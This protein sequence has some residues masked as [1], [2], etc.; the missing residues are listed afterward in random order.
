LHYVQSFSPKVSDYLVS[1]LPDAVRNVALLDANKMLQGAAVR[2][3]SSSPWRQTVNQSAHQE[4]ALE[5]DGR[6]LQLAQTFQQGNFTLSK[7]YT[8]ASTPHLPGIGQLIQFYGSSA[9]QATSRLDLV[10]GGE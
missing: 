8:F 5:T 1:L 2:L 3:P 6:T 10:G 9:A 4:S 7:L